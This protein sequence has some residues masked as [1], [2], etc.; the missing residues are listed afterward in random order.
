M[1][2]DESAGY[3]NIALAY[4]RLGEFRTEE[5]YYRLALS[6]DSQDTHAL[7][8]L[9]VNLAH[10]GRFEEALAIMERLEELEGIEPYGDLHRSKIHAAMDDRD[11]AYSYL[12][13]AL[14]GMARL[15]TLH[16]I[17]FRQDIRIDPAF[18]ELRSERRFARLLRRFYGEEG[19]R[20]L[21]GG[22]HG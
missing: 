6:L 19:A 5:A 12:E 9:A 3:N 17:E 8:N 7:N 13:R 15:D 21:R 20:G 14:E 1:N 11:A 16:H 4:K 10:Q 18:R 22:A 2:P